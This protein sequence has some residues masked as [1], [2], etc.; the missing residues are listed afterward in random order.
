L[1][2]HH[3]LLLIVGAPDPTV[4]AVGPDV[5]QSQPI[6]PEIDQV[7]R[8]LDIRGDDGLAAGT[9]DDPMGL[10]VFCDN[11][12]CHAG[13]GPLSRRGLSEGMKAKKK[14]NNE[15]PGPNVLGG[16]EFSSLH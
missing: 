7:N 3:H 12:G 2:I 1:A 9:S 10:A 6:H 5:A 11:R 4:K 14:S 13:Q 8:Y 16:I 15:S